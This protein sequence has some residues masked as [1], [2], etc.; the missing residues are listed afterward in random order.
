MVI[1][2]KS[3]DAFFTS[4]FHVTEYE[5]QSAA[6][7][8]SKPGVPEVSGPLRLVKIVFQEILFRPMRGI[9]D[10]KIRTAIFLRYFGAVI[11]Y[12][13]YDLISI[14]PTGWYSMSP[15]EHEPYLLFQRWA[16]FA[17]IAVPLLLWALTNE[18]R[19][20]REIRTRVA[21]KLSLARIEKKR[22]GARKIFLRLLAIAVGLLLFDYI[23][24]FLDNLNTSL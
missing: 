8:E 10:L 6:E 4:V 1:R 19:F 11:L 23:P 20:S 21:L 3:E 24:T 12:L 2:W 5:R 22:I 9:K 13:I 14:K 7:Y 17:L 18:I 15:T 16:Y